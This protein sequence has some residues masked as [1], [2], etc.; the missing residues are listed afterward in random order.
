MAT[1]ATSVDTRS[2]E[3]PAPGLRALPSAAAIEAVEVTRRFGSHVALDEVS[4][5]VRTGEIHALLGPNGAGKT[6]LLRALTGLV[7]PDAGTVRV[8]GED[9]SRAARSTRAHTGFV[10]SG[11]RTFYLRLSGLEN[12]LFFARLHGIRKREAVRRALEILDRCGLSGA[13]RKPVAGYSHG[14]QKRLSLGRALLTAPAVLLV[15]EATHDLDPEASSGV[16]LIV[17]ELARQGTAV[18]WATQRI[19]EI[20]GFAHQVTLL[21]GGRLRFTG[22]V[23]SLM[24]RAEARRFV[25]RLDVRDGPGIRDAMAA[26]LGETGEIEHLDAEHWLLCVG[27]DTVLGQAVARLSGSGIAVLGCHRERSELEEAFM[28]LSGTASE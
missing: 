16:R 13:A 3:N 12:L 7:A 11:D 6:T 22:S 2:V 8:L 1:T 5:T 21:G 27:T 19:D 28:T 24:A 4:L 26:A 25:L 20:R 9:A 14:M 23:P 15:D 10:P 18:L 17:E